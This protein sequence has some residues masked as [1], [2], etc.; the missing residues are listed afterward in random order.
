MRWMFRRIAQS[1]APSGA[2]CRFAQTVCTYQLDHGQATPVG[3]VFAT[4]GV[5]PDTGRTVALS[6]VSLEDHEGRLVAHGGS[7][8][9]VFPSQSRPPGPTAAPAKEPE[10]ATPDPH[11]RPVVGEMLPQSV[12]E[13]GRDA[14][15]AFGVARRP[16]AR[17]RTTAARRG[18]AGSPRS[19]GAR[20]R[21]CRA[22]RTAPCSWTSP[23]CRRGR[24]VRGRAP[25]RSP[26]PP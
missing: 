25:R 17:L 18:A 19:A 26:P 13:L 5:R 11:L 15:R 10:H 6:D 4:A 23:A 20:A 16:E 22:R 8:L 14:A 1:W 7:L 21:A 24:S 9:F 2:R 12:F 3:Y